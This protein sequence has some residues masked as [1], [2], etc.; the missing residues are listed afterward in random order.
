[1]SRTGPQKAKA[2]KQSQGKIAAD[3][4]MEQ[5]VPVVMS[6]G[7]RLFANVFRPATPGRYPAILSVTPYGKD[8]L[9]DRKTVFFMRLSRVRF[10]K[11]R[12]SRWTG[13][14][15]ADPMYWVRQGYVVAQADVR[16]MHTSE[17]FAGMLTDRDAA[18]Y[19]TFIE[20]AAKQTWCNGRVGLL[21]VSY[22]AM[23]QWRV[24][25]LMPP[26]LKAICPW[27]GGA[28]IDVLREMAYHDGVPETGFLTT[29]WKM[30]IVR[31]HNRRFPVAEDFPADSEKHPLDDEYWAAKRPDLRKIA[32]P[33]LVC[34]SWS[35][36]GLHA[37]GSFAGFEE[38]G[39]SEKWLFTHGR[40]KIEVFYSDEAL[41]VQTAFFAHTLQERVDAMKTVPTV[42]IERRSS[43]YKADVRG[44]P[45]WPLK[46]ALAHHLSLS[47]SS[48]SLVDQIPHEVSVAEYESTRKNDTAAFSCTFAE[49]TE[50]TGSMALKLWVSSPESDD[51]DLF[52]TVHKMDRQGK[53]VFFPGFNGFSK[54]CVAKGWLRASLRHCDA[55]RSTTFRPWHDL[56]EKQLVRPGD[57][58]P[59]E[60]EIQ[61]SSTLFEAGT[62]LRLAVQG[63]D[64]PGYVVLAHRRS[65]NHG[66][67][68]IHC[69]STYDSR[70]TVPIVAAPAGNPPPR[71]PGSR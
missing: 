42:R 1:M 23:S 56:K 39:S 10:G 71:A 47:A 53:E 7:V 2:P 22:L 38:I 15:S 24:A 49:D 20:W 25:A 68:R 27:E 37:R 6:D 18:D 57:I 45:T 70:L 65:V 43:Y 9:P 62:T 12:H 34:G 32:V 48:R 14:E 51:L 29:W 50:I 67:H 11:V 69:G 26:S 63:R 17:G 28:A 64:P 54:D 61:P 41:A 40:R 58:V 52:V 46:D 16:G 55:K 3:I 36:H 8:R 5:N 19:A 4:I 44:E 66:K 21:G 33:I 60:I 30:R 31:G 35:D 13:F 59:V